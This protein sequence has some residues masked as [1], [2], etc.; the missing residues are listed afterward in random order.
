MSAPTISRI[1][2]TSG[3]TSGGTTVIITGTNLASPSAVTFGGSSATIV[4]SSATSISVTAPANAAG[5]VRVAVT[6]GAGTSTQAVN[7]T[8]VTVSAPTITSLSPTSGPPSGGTTVTINGT[9]LLYTTGVSFGGNAASSFAVLSNTQV[10]AIA[11]AGTPG[12][13]TVTVTNSAGTSGTLPYTYTGTAAPSVSSVSPSSGP[14]AGGNTVSIGGSGFTYATAVTFGSTAATSFTVVSSSV[15]SAVVPPGPSAG[16][17][18]SVL[19]TGPGGTSAA[20][21]TYTYTAAPTPTI[22]ALTPSS[23]TVSGGNTVTIAGSNFSGATAVTFAGTPATSFTVLSPTQVNAVAPAGAAG[24]AA[25]VV[26]TPAA[27]SAGFNYIYVAAPA[28]A[29]VFPTSGVLAGNDGVTITGTG[30][31]GTTSVKFGTYHASG[32]TVVSDTELDAVTPA[33]LAGT[34]PISIATPGGTDS[35]L[36]FGYQ[37]APVISSITPTSGSTTGGTAVN[38]TG[39]GLIDALQ[40]YFGT[41]PATGFTVNSDNAITATSPAGTAGVSAVTVSTDASTSNGASFLYVNAPTLT[42]LSPTTGSIA[43]GNNV[44]LTGTGFS[45]AT[46]VFFGPNPAS[47]SLIDDT[48]ISAVAPSGTG[49]VSVTVSNPGG[50]SGSE[51]YTY[52]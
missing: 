31:T 33:H 5:T 29:A 18:V 30:L 6:T 43:G 41:T 45:T 4:S 22:T 42:S 14:A 51:G 8:Y 52:A 39:A 28:P 27:A 21:T 37:P 40:V 3:P 13:T 10:S 15:I 47:F 38:I 25:V 16:G 23:G 12:A 35:S 49:T 32:F 36:T 46:D 1:N 20:G 48:L 44:T 9:N 34:V 19:V 50:T 17:A 2:P 11:P 7:F 24:N 26:T